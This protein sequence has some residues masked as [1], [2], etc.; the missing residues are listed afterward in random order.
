MPSIN[1]IVVDT[2]VII[3]YVFKQD[4]RAELYRKDLD[5]KQLIVSFMIVAELKFWANYR[6]WGAT[7]IAA[8]EQHLRRMIIYPVDAKLIDK[9]AQ[10]MAQAEKAGRRMDSKDA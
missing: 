10:I 1:R 9:W 6:N 3:S 8:L 7:R 4:S 2:N 5:N